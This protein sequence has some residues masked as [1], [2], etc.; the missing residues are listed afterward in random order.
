MESR[1]LVSVSRRVSSS[2]FLSRFWVSKCHHKILQWHPKLW[3]PIYTFALYCSKTIWGKFVFLHVAIATDG[4]NVIGRNNFL[5]QKLEAKIVRM[6]SMHCQAH[7]LVSAFYYAA[8]DLYSMVYE[9]AKELSC[10]YG[11][12]LLFHRCDRLSWRCVRLQWRQKSAVAARMQNKLAVE[13]GN[14]ESK[15]W[16][17][18]WAAL[19][20]ISENKNDGNVRCLSAIYENKKNS[21]WYFPFANIATSPDRAQQSFLGGMF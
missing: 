4:C 21:K 6:V 3:K 15:V 16:A 11:S 9:T 7:R 13:W 19:K 8:A 12:V 20:Q 10:N 18:V 1:D 5:A 17:A 14:S 2:D